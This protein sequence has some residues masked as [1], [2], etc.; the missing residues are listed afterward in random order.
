MGWSPCMPLREG[1]EQMCAWYL[2]E[3]GP[4]LA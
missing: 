2:Q 3:A 1:L 4:V